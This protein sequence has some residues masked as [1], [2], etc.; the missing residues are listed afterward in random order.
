MSRVT[1]LVV[2]SQL[3]FLILMAICVAI[4]PHFLFTHNEGGMS[5]YGVHDKTVV[6]YTLALV[7][8][9]SFL[10]L[11]VRELPKRSDYT[12]L[13]MIFRLTACS[14]MLV[15]LTTYPYKHSDFFDN[16]HT[17]ANIVAFLFQVIA[18]GWIALG[19]QRTRTNI[20][21]F[22]FQLVTFA[23]TLLTFFGALHILFIAQILT[24]LSFGLLLVSS[25]KD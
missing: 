5:N 19:F 9:A 18:G 13:R 25:T 24:V 6:F 4:L 10:L 8:S 14:L 1:K 23:L 7:S 3:S 2:L 12:R 22:C 16:L 20:L 15:L 17:A 11:A 21:L